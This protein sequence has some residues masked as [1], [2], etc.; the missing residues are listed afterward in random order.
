VSERKSVLVVDGEKD[1]RDLLKQHLST[2]GYNVLCAK[3][4]ESALEIARD[5]S[6][7]L[8]I[9]DLMLSGTSG[10][11]V[12]SCIRSKQTNKYIS[13]IIL[14][15]CSATEDKLKGFNAGADDYIIKPFSMR[16]LIARVKRV[17]G[18]QQIKEE[19]PIKHYLGDLFIEATKSMVKVERLSDKAPLLT[20]KEKKILGF[21]IMQQGDLVT[22]NELIDAVWNKDKFVE[23]GNVSVHIRHLRE[24]IEKNPQK[25]KI[26]KTVQG[27]GYRF[28]IAS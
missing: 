27:K 19:L 7:D 18:R 16:E 9:L 4:G 5:K 11:Q 2:A 1:V 13:I 20:E 21:L 8:I 15:A 14:S 12:C 23:H 3:N 22:H 17:L 6:P 28:E 10:L 25:P 24:K 26:I